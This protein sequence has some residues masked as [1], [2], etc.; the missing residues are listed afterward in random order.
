M[1]TLLSRIKQ[2]TKQ[3]EF[4]RLV[5]A[6]SD[7]VTFYNPKEVTELILKAA[8]DGQTEFKK[9]YNTSNAVVCELQKMFALNPE[10]KDI[11]ITIIYRSII[12][13]PALCFSW[14]VK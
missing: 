6:Q 14:E 12:S 4:D 3:G 5:E 7:A 11:E 9:S 10:F 1:D 8:Y 2:T 13:S